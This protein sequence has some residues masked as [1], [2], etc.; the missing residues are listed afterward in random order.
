MS[1]VISFYQLFSTWWLH[2]GDCWS[3]HCKYIQCFLLTLVETSYHLVILQCPESF[4]DT[5]FFR[6]L[7]RST[8]S[9]VI[10]VFWHTFTGSKIATFANWRMYLVNRRQDKQSHLCYIFMRMLLKPYCKSHHGRVHLISRGRLIWHP[11]SR[12]AWQKHCI[13]CI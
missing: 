1:A 5:Y 10:I 11:Q 8:L 4:I 13:E 12:L 2:V 7:V 6:S 3:A 9:L